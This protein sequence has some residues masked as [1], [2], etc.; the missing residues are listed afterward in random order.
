MLE[1]SVEEIELILDWEDQKPENL[2]KH[3]FQTNPNSNNEIKKSST[4]SLVECIEMFSI[5]EELSEGNQWFCENCSDL[6]QAYKKLKI[7]YSP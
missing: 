2:P 4:T 6:K 5:D 3:T 7:H 1:K